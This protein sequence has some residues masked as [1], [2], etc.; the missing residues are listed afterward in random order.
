M[1]EGFEVKKVSDTEWVVVDKDLD[2]DVAS[3]DTEEEALKAKR[4]LELD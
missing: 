1:D 3:Y 4:S 2:I